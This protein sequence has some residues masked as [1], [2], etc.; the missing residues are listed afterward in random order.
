MRI[1]PVTFLIC[2]FIL[3]AGTMAVPPVKN[4]APSSIDAQ[5][6]TDV[7]ASKK[8]SRPRKPKVDDTIIQPTDT[9]PAVVR[10]KSGRFVKNQNP[11]P[12]PEQKSAPVPVPVKEPKSAPASSV[13]PKTAEPG[14]TA[15]CQDGTFSHSKQHSGS[16][17]RHGG[18][19]Q[20]L[21]E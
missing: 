5:Q 16:C 1:L 10:D 13:A 19:A 18:V 2:G 15:R 4:D 6:T 7:P 11:L 3:S 20:W 17:S 8:V 9:V 14:A 21:V 12:V